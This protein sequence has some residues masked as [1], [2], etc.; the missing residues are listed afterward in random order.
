MRAT[1]DTLRARLASGGAWD[2]LVLDLRGN[3][4]GS[5]VWGDEIASAIFGAAWARQARAWLNDGVYTEWRVSKDNVEAVRGQVKQLETRHGA[6]SPQAAGARAFADSMAAAL[7]RGDLLYSPGR[8]ARQ[9]LTRPTAPPLPGKVVVVTTASCFSACL[10]F[11]DVMR[12]HPAVVQV[13]QPTGVDTDYMENWGWPLPS[14]LSQIG[15]P[16]KVY[17]NRRR[18]NNEGYAPQVRRDD[19]ADTNALAEWIRRD[20][21]KW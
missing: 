21:Q 18:A 6:D 13:G 15:Y 2:L 14:G 9:G 10:D 12:L 17:R 4:G 16:M 1:I 8:A 20:Y 3:S 7:A 5:S 11:L 19:L